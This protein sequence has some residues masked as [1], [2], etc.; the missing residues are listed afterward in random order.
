MADR[1]P[2]AGP[3]HYLRDL[4]YGGLDGAITTLAVVAGAQGADLGRSVALI[5]GFANLGADGI[6]M[7]A[8]NYLGLKSD[9]E[10]RG[11]SVEEEK[12]VLHG[13]AT[14]AS[15]VI[16]GLFPLLAYLPPQ[17]VPRLPVAAALTGLTLFATG[18]LRARFIGRPAA[19]LGLEMV[20]VGALAAVA[21]F[22]IG[23]GVRSLL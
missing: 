12:P 8:S 7:A 3:G 11:L 21:A 19:A 17:D 20:L 15:F 2:A 22:A 13:L 4:V 23:A 9:L 10:Q 18:A 16:A 1:R 14:F 5:L 6:S